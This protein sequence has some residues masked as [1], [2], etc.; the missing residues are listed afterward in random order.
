MR[1]GGKSSWLD[2]QSEKL[3]VYVRWWQSSPAGKRKKKRP[4]WI[5]ERFWCELRGSDQR[6]DLENTLPVR[7]KAGKRQ[8]RRLS[9]EVR[10]GLL[11][12]CYTSWSKRRRNKCVLDVGTFCGMG[13]QKPI[14][15][16][17]AE[18][19][20]RKQ[21]R[22]VQATLRVETVASAPGGDFSTGPGL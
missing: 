15:K 21:R 20:P 9:K 4:R 13:G 1:R 12:Q 5:I 19:E 17:E 2:T 10:S 11:Y 22:E 7:R 8:K 6:E 18:W 3:S 14:T 16:S